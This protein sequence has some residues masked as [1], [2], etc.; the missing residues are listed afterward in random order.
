MAGCRFHHVPYGFVAPAYLLLLLPVI[1]AGLRNRWSQPSQRIVPRVV[2]DAEPSNYER[3][4]TKKL[5]V[6]VPEARTSDLEGNISNRSTRRHLWEHYFVHNFTDGDTAALKNDTHTNNTPPMCGPS[7]T[8]FDFGFYD[9]A[10]A[11][12]LLEAGFCVLGVEADPYLVKQA[13]DK[14]SVWLYTGQLR[15]ANVAVSPK[16]NSSTWTQFYV[17]KC[18]REWNSFY[19]TTACRSCT[20]PHSLSADAC[21][22]VSVRSM[23]CLDV[24]RQFGAAQYLKLDIEG[25]ETGCLAALALPDARA[26]LPQFLSAEI[27]QIDY[28]DSLF[29]VGYRSFKLVRQDVLHSG[30]SS[31]SGPW[32]NHALDCRS[33][34]TWR[35]YA[36]AREEFQAILSKP[37]NQHDPCPGG[38]CGIHDAGCKDKAYIWYDVHVTWG[39]P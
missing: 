7:N 1:A 11:K 2:S 17:N 32:G 26:S 10:D 19:Y 20:P 39:L 21:S 33:G 29:H 18:M 15:L 5:P 22:A 23:S 4:L 24:L 13:V 37:F 35:T 9:G 38:L 8:I 6:F 16:G 12:P 27:T 14:F 34:A 31:L 30:T 36:E 28:L 25:A 3:S